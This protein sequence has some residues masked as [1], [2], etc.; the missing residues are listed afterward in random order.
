MSSSLLVVITNVFDAGVLDEAIIQPR[1]TPAHQPMHPAYAYAVQ[2]LRYPI[3]DSH[4]K[5]PINSS[6]FSTMYDS[7]SAVSAGC[8]P[9]HSRFFMMSSEIRKSPTTR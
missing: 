2:V 1:C 4:Q 8:T 9:I 3:S 6:I 5:C 7:I